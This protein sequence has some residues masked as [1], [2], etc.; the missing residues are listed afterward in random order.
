MN[1][2]VL[3]DMKLKEYEVFKPIE[4]IW[5]RKKRTMVVTNR[6]FRNFLVQFLK[7]FISQKRKKRRPI[8]AGAFKYIQEIW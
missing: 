1:H 5:R 4:N 8:F 7:N 2:Y 6:M 3:K